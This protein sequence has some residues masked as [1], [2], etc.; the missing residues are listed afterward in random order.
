MA[1][2]VLLLLVLMASLMACDIADEFDDYEDDPVDSEV[3]TVGNTAVETNDDPID[4]DPTPAEPLFFDYCPTD[5]DADGVRCGYFYVPENRTAESSQKIEL[6]FA[7]LPAPNKQY[8]DPI[9]YLAGGPGGSAIFEL[10]SDVEGWQAYQFAQERDLIFLD[11]RGTGYSSP[12][13]NCYELDDAEDPVRAETACYERL[14]GMGIDL[15][16]YN[17]IENA[18]DVAD[19]MQA[20][21]YETYNVLGISYGTRLALTL[22]RD[23]PQGIRSMVLDS[24]FPP[25]APTAEEEALLTY[26]AIQALFADCRADADCNNAY[27]NLEALFLQTVA[28]LDNDPDAEIFGDDLVFA[29]TSALNAGSDTAVL[30]PLMILEVSQ[31]EYGLL[32]EILGSTGYTRGAQSASHQQGGDNDGDSEGMH[33]AVICRDEFAFSSYKTASAALAQIPEELHNALFYSSTASTFDTCEIWRTGEAP[34]VENQPVVSDIP[35]LV[36]VGQYDP[37]T[38][39]AWGELT[40][41]SLS[42]SYLFEFRGGGHSLLSDNIC[43]IEAAEAFIANPTAEPDRTCVNEIEPP[44]FELP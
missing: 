40:A 44:F 18:T 3:D 30:I 6:V 26:R 31:G 17:T 11:Q 16:G 19:L 4:P 13:L 1:Q 8:D 5:I 43:A 27:P 29:V 28:D 37:A 32:D 12:S 33:T 10:A 38:P 21:G 15:S 35:A 23:H 22:M 20:F 2:R 34:D 9:I 36:L 7:I 39:L 41:Q 25:N 24:P 42:R 14:V